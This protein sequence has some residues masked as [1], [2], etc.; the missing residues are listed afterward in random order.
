MRMGKYWN[1]ENID[2]NTK[3]RIQKIITG[4][5]DEK[6][7][8]RVRDLSINLIEESDFQ[9][10]PMW[11][12]CYIVYDRHSEA[13]EI[14]KWEKPEDIDKYLQEFKQHSLRNPIVEQ[15][16]TETLRTVRDIWKQVGQ[17]D[18]IHVEL[19]REMKNPVEEI[20]RMTLQSIENEKTNLRI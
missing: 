19:G 2:T 12:A 14:Q 18:E 10:L 8:N 17:I 9:G 5:Y 4:E 20:S 16:I 15:V 11:L 1:Y 6:I 7:R 3:D 13:K